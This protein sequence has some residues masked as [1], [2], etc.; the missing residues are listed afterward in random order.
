MMVQPFSIIKSDQG[1]F[2]PKRLL[3]FFMLM[4]MPV[5][6]LYGQVDE[7]EEEVEPI[8]EERVS[9]FALKKYVQIGASTGFMRLF[10]ELDNDINPS[11]S[12]RLGG[13][14]QLNYGITPSMTLGLAFSTGS[15]FGHVRSDATSP[16]FTN[17]NVRTTVFVPQLRLGYHF[18]GHYHNHLPGVFQPWVFTG[19]GFMFFNPL[20]DL[21]NDQ[22]VPYHYWSDGSIRD[23][24]ETPDNLSKAVFM[25]RDYFYE[26]VLRDADFDGLGP[27]PKMALTIPVGVGF[28]FNL[29]QQFALSVGATFHYTF[30]DHLDNITPKSGAIDPNR[31]IGKT[32]N[33]AFLLIHAGISFKHYEFE[34]IARGELNIPPPSTLP[35]DFKPFDLNDNDAIDREEVLQALEDLFNGDSAYPLELIELLIDF[36][37][38]RQSLDDRI[39]Y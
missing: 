2:L 23:L 17:L 25:N 32:G 9:V 37:N 8:P 31:A 1:T 38:I 5:V 4:M 39:H 21:T 12:D 24:P 7:V 22:G 13:G 6:M 3:V 11:F 29:N 27:F 34:P 35:I 28:D 15:L 26:T 33:D 18:A 16:L 36:Y 10:A 14:L 30:T 20:A 19:I